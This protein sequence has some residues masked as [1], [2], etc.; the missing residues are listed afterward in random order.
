LHENTNYKQTVKNLYNYPASNPVLVNPIPS[1]L[2]HFKIE[3]CFEIA[4]LNWTSVP[5]VLQNIVLQLQL[6]CNRLQLWLSMA[7][8]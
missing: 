6:K 4:E 3:S 1:T 2:A 7:F 5:W 8:S